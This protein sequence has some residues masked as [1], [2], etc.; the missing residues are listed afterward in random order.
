MKKQ[1]TL[2]QTYLDEIQEL[3]KAKNYQEALKKVKEVK[4]NNFWTMKQNDILDQL[5]SVITRLYTKKVNNEI[6][7]KMSKKDI[8]NEILSKNKLNLSLFDILVNRF[9]D[10]I[11]ERDIDLYIQEWLN[12]KTISNVDKYYILTGL[13]T[14]DKL[15]KAKLTV[16]NSNQK[17]ILEIDLKDWD[18]DFHKI[19]YYQNTFNQIDKY[20]FKTPSYSK[21]AEAI[22]DTISMWHF[23]TKTDYEINELS[24][25]I[26]AYVEFLTQQ[27]DFN[28]IDFFKWIESILRKQEI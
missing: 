17:K 12:S 21:F 13:K 20:F 24:K 1:D 8:L 27:K 26:I 7:D 5:D 25:N 4:E 23:G 28:D 9:G 11:E 2:F 19:Q 22:I 15:P 16:Y 14:L 18:E 3:T 10:Q 6:I